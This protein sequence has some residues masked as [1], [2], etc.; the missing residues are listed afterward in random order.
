MN[1]R[2]PNFHIFQET[3]LCRSQGIRCE[4]FET[5]ISWEKDK[6]AFIFEDKPER[7]IQKKNRWKK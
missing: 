1:F 2:N 5:K 6:R 4:E 7:E 3:H